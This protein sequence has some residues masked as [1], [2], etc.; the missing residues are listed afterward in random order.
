MAGRTNSRCTRSTEPTT[1]LGSAVTLGF[2]LTRPNKWSRMRIP[3]LSYRF[4]RLDKV[5]RRRRILSIQ[6]A[7]L[8]KALD[9]LGHIQPTAA[10]RRVEWQDTMSE[11]PAQPGWIF[12]TDQIIHNQQ[13]P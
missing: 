6:R 11:T 1:F 13:D 7:A 4:E 5:L 12:V 3:M 9:R 10:E 8:E 2:A